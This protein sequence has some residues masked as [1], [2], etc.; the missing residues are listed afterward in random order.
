MADKRD[1]Y[2]ILGVDKGADEETIKKAYRKLAKQLHPDVNPGDKEAEQKFKEVNEAYSVLSDKD[3]RAAYDQYG[4]AAFDPSSGMGGG[5]GF[6]GFDFGG[7]DF[8]DIFGNIF[9]GGFGGSSSSRRNA[10]LK[11]SDIRVS[12][13]ISF[14][15]AF[16]GCKKDIT[17]KRIE[18]C[19]E[20]GGNGAAK[21]RGSGRISV[22]RNTMLGQMT[23]QTT[24]DACR[25]SGKVV[26]NPCTNCRGTG[27]V[28]I[29]KKV[30]VTVP[31]GIDDGQ[32]I[33]QSGGGDA[34]RNGGGPGDLVI[35]VS[36]RPHRI[37]ERFGNDIAC[38]VPITFTE[39]A[40]G[41]ELTIPTMDG[42]VKYKIPEGTQNGTKFRIRGKGEPIYNSTNKGD[43]IF[44]VNIEI[45]KNLDSKQKEL[46]KQ[47]A[48][49]SKDS[50]YQKKKSFF[51]KIF[52]K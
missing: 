2:E 51:D 1:Y 49:M 35:F 37:F 16:F 25:G 48:D 5:A 22:T 27:Y 41:A 43:L 7:M 23:T 24:C 26:K 21:G 45:P 13:T 15:E 46:L 20:C 28:K 47:F 6:G 9:G 32:R 42:D 14:D 3:K 18:Y 30:G 17:Y 44:T 50:N 10:P 29:N 40:L 31:A 33:V 39:A 19:P 38:E 4:H 52:R 8:G 34:G 36:V 12:L 11:G